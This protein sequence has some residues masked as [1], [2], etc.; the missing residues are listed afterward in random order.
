MRWRRK[1]HESRM[2]YGPK[3]PRGFSEKGSARWR[4]TSE[5]HMKQYSVCSGV[6]TGFGHS[7]I[8]ATAPASANTSDAESPMP[9]QA[10]KRGTWFLS[11]LSL[12]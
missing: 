12:V 3:W 11:R 6:V 7:A 2:S 5:C 9:P 1:I 4:A 8:R 10:E